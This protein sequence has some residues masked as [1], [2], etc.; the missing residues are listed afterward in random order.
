MLSK[1][2]FVIIS[3]HSFDYL[4]SVKVL[5]IRKQLLQLSYSFIYLFIYLLEKDIS[6]K[7]TLQNEVDQTKVVQYLLSYK[8]IK[9][10]NS[11]NRTIDQ[12]T[13]F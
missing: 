3:D 11:S 1:P 13:Q 9:P 7:I 2:V 5:F 6:N 10:I 12:I 4:L 8:Y